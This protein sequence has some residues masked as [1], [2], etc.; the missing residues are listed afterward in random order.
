MFKIN[1]SVRFK[2]G[3]KDENSGINIGGWQGRIIEISKKH[4][5]VLVALDSV[6]LKN[7]S[8]DYLEECEEEGLGWPEYNIGFDDV[9][10]VKPRDTKKDVKKTIGDLSNSLRWSYLGEEGRDINAV[11]EGA[12][13]L[14]DQLEAWDAYLEK[15]LKFPFAAEISEWQRPGSALQAGQKVRVMEIEDWDDHYGILVKVKKSRR[16]YIF[17]LS[18]LE[19]TPQKSPNHDPVQLYAVWFANQ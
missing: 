16:S 1:D 10:P 19:A 12:I 6:T 17:P 9:E 5:M 13:S 2:D 14:S 11:L 15:E 8:H 7:L 18:D 3:Q 4:K